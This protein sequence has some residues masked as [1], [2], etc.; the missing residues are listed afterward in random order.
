MLMKRISLFP[1]LIFTGSLISAQNTTENAGR[2][3]NLD[4][5]FKLALARSETLAQHGE[6]VEQLYAEI[7]R[8]K[9]GF[10]P[11]VEF[12]ASQIW[13]DKS[14]DNSSGASSS[15]QTSRPQALVNLHQPLFSGMRDIFA[16][17]SAETQRLSVS[18]GLERAKQL[19]YQNTAQAYFGLLQIHHEITLRGEQIELTK[20]RID[21]LQAREKIGRSRRS[22]ILAAQAQMLQ[23]EAQLADALG[24]EKV[25]Q[26]V[27]RFL[28]GLE[29]DARPEEA[30]LPDANGR[31]HYLGKIQSRY[32]IKAA[33]F[34][35]E[36]AQLQTDIRR[37]QKLPSLSFDGNYYL[38]RP[39]G[40]LETIR[41]DAGFFLGLPLYSGGSI[42]AQIK[43][44]EAGERFAEQA[45]TLVLRQAELDVNSA[46]DSLRSSLLVTSVL[47]KAVETAQANAEAQSADYLLGLVTNL[48]VLNSLSSV[49]ELKLQ[50]ENAKISA[51]LQRI[52][53]ETAAGGPEIK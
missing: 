26:R 18:C 16:V 32:D 48:E 1:L 15:N 8:I 50:F 17:R 34:N 52:Y 7:E 25:R 27:F 31:K 36:Y 5:S 21:E 9:A 28:A 51:S 37:R 43:Q 20:K 38:K 41:W 39:R 11:A 29:T 40:S 49:Q 44:S 33:R 12:N 35:L 42:G 19:L 10:R 14:S 6:T 3:I 46:Y 4:Q 23:N 24:R 53:L 13:Q 30:R 2:S 47:E 45:L 22:E